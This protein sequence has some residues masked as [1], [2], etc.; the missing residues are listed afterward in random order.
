MSFQPLGEDYCSAV[1][2]IVDIVLNQQL[3]GHFSALMIAWTQ[4]SK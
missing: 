3:T 4:I 2:T 1:C